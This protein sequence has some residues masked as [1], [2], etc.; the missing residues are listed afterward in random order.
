[1]AKSHQKKAATHSQ[2]S[3]WPNRT[4]DSLEIEIV[5]DFMHDANSEIPLSPPVVDTAVDV[6]KLG[7]NCH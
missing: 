5:L 4:Q 3:K 1:M 6:S 2:A 7:S